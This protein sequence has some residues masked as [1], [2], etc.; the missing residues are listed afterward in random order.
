MA[1]PE[2]ERLDEL[3]QG[4]VL[5]AIVHDHDLEFRVAEADEAVHA[6][7]HARFFVVDRADEGH[8]LVVAG[9]EGG[10]EAIGLHFV[11]VIPD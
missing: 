10:I 2:P 9:L 3:F 11:E 1:G 8:G 4:G 7:H 5:A 6:V